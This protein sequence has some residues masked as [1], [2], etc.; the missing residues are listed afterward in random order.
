MTGRAN[1]HMIL[2]APEADLVTRLDPKLVS[3]L[4]GDD[5]LSLRPNT[6]SHTV[7][8]NHSSDRR[9]LYP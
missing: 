4:L 7:E 3:Q 9:I 6:M 1:R 5:D 2:V 8:Y